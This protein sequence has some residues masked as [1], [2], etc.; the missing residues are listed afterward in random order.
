MKSTIAG[1]ITVIL[2][3]ILFMAKL[4]L[5]STGA[6]GNGA[7]LSFDVDSNENIYIGT[8]GKINVYKDGLRVKSITL[9]NDDQYRFYIENDTI[10]IGF[11]SGGKSGIY[12]LDGNE[13]SADGVAYSDIG[14][15]SKKNTSFVNGHEY[16]FSN[17][18]GLLPYTITRDGAEVHRMSTLDYLL[19]GFP[20]G[21]AC[22]FL[23]FL[24]AV[25]VIIKASA[26]QKARQ[27]GNDPWQAVLGI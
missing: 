4:F 16:K 24:T 1:I 8:M 12:D 3:F 23:F 7:V 25:F 19:N 15:I 18:L 9:H 11:A 22:L 13:L 2:W 14:S 20:F 5:S 17:G 26:Y 6:I 21:L 27:N 10:I